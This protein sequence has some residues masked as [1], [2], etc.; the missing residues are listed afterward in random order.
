MRI[1]WRVS[2]HS[3]NLCV[4]GG[5]TQRTRWAH[6]P[7]CPGQCRGLQP[8]TPSRGLCLL[9]GACPRPDASPRLSATKWP[10]PRKVRSTPPGVRGRL[11]AAL[12]A[13]STIRV[14]SA[15]RKTGHTRTQHGGLYLLA[16]TASRHF[17][18]T[19]APVGEKPCKTLACG[20][21]TSSPRGSGSC[22]GGAAT[23]AS[24]NWSPARGS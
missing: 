3:V 8:S 20:R 19:R 6:N 14:V 2:T 17:C 15:G 22:A 16:R 1:Y 7:Q 11:L 24:P 4:A 21:L 5:R 12:H 23:A 9:K 18:G 10:K 13:V